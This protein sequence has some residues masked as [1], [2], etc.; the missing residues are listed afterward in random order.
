MPPLRHAP[1]GGRL[2]W[3]VVTIVSAALLAIVV[4]N[5]TTGERKI[6]YVIPTQFGVDD[7]QFVRS[8][9][10][11][12]GP[13]LVPGNRCQ[14]L[15]NGAQIFP[16][17][18]DAIRG[19]RESIAFETYI[20]WSGEIGREFAEALAERARAGVSVHVLLDWVGAGRIEERYLEQMR[21]AGV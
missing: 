5:L 7:P 9:S 19:A 13:P 10:H 4:S 12:L 21:D 16:A 11:L 15:L 14:E 20:Y 8:M 2:V 17:M 6:H 3:I 18:L 1:R